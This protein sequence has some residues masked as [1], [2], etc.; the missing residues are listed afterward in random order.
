MTAERTLPQ[1]NRAQDVL[2]QDGS[3]TDHLPQDEQIIKSSCGN[4]YTNA[5]K[6]QALTLYAVGV[7]LTEIERLLG[8]KKRAVHNM[9]QIAKKRGWDPHIDFRLLDKHVIVDLSTRGRKKRIKCVDDP[10]AA[11]EIQHSHPQIPTD[12]IP[13]TEANW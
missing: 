3:T 5:Q 4:R 13:E 2:A 9:L 7:R 8:V 11:V 10:A 6:T 1:Y 12:N